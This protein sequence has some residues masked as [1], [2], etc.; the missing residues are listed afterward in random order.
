M[1][2]N[3]NP[4]LVGFQCA[5]HWRPVLRL[6]AGTVALS[7][8]CH[9]KTSGDSHLSLFSLSFH[10]CF[11][12]A[13]IYF[14]CLFSC[15]FCS[16]FTVSICLDLPKY[17]PFFFSSSFFISQT[18]FLNSLSLRSYFRSLALLEGPFIIIENVFILLLILKLFSL[19]VKF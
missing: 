18:F 11:P 12:F 3:P 5:S 6:P 4:L 17:F 1:A 2:N 8:S 15:C 9:G 14:V 7:D 10:C 16:C 13:F 19:D